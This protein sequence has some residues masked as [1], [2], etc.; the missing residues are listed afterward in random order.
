ME[1][2]QKQDAN[3]PVYSSSYPE[4]VQ[5]NEFRIR[6]T[7]ETKIGR[8]YSQKVTIPNRERHQLQFIVEFI[9]MIHIFVSLVSS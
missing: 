2:V 3:C 4:F 9:T 7:I 6:G 1:N 5:A 8:T